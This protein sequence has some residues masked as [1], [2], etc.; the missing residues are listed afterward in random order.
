MPRSHMPD[1]PA[2][3]TW[4][5]CMGTTWFETSKSGSCD[6]SRALNLAVRLPFLFS[7]WADNSVDLL[8]L[9]F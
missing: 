9:N 5:E 4:F 1:L 8:I 3:H 2:R 7:I 6:V